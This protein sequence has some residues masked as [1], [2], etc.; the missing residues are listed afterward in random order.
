MPTPDVTVVRL[1]LFCEPTSVVAAAAD[2]EDGGGGWTTSW[3]PHAR[4]VRPGTNLRALVAVHRDC[5][6]GG[7][8]ATVE[9]GFHSGLYGRVR[10]I[11]PDGTFR[12]LG[13]AQAHVD[14]Y[15]DGRYRFSKRVQLEDG[16]RS[17]GIWEL[18]FTGG[19]VIETASLA[20]EC[21][22]P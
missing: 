9:L 14:D 6:L 3:E 12:N 20:F 10:L 15:G 18:V 17:A 1:R 2:A 13:L 4:S 19:G 21:S 5:A 16:S 22:G 11:S 7:V 8:T